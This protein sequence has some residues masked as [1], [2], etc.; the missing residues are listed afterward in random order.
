MLPDKL[1]LVVVL[2][3]NQ[4]EKKV[5]VPPEWKVQ[6]FIEHLIKKLPLPTQQG[7]QG[8]EY[9]FVLK[10]TDT[11]LDNDKTLQEQGVKSGDVLRIRKNITG[12]S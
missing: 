4:G 10:R 9:S 5:S 1:Q 6:K 8:I 12:G 11:A 2:P 7:I 3:D